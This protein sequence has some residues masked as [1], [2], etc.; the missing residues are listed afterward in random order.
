MK[1]YKPCLA[2][3]VALTVTTGSTNVF[4]QSSS[5]VDVPV[6]IE[7]ENYSSMV[8]IRL[9]ETSDNGGGT[10]VGWIQDRDYTEYNISVPSSGQYRITAR[11][12]SN[13]DG[14]NIDFRV[15]GETL[16]S[17]EV[18]HTGGWNDFRNEETTLDLREG[19][20][21]LQLLYTSSRDGHLLNVNSFSIASVD[22]SS[23]NPVPPP[24]APP[25]G[26][27]VTAATGTDTLQ[28]AIDEVNSEGGGTVLL[29]SG[30]YNLTQEIRP[31][32][33]VHILG[34]GSS[35]L[36]RWHNSVAD[37]INVPVFNITYGSG[38]DMGFENFKI[39]CRVDI[40][41]RDDRNRT[42]TRGI[43]LTGGGSQF[44]PGSAAFRNIT[45]KDLEIIN[46]G[47]E[48]IQIKGAHNVE[49]TDLKLRDNGWGT[50]DLWHNFYLK[51]VSK[52][53][54]RQTGSDTG[55]MK[56]SPSGHGMR[57]SDLDDVYLEG[58]SVFGNADHGIHMDNVSDFRA[59][60]LDL[61][62]NCQIPNGTCRESA[63]YNDCDYD[64]TS[65]KE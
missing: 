51:R 48:G 6:S 58:V 60:G 30:T 37:R 55:Y 31:R 39:D 1:N 36:V 20:Q 14:G 22:D 45:L 18:D 50:T 61:G 54:V 28:S 15:G 56:D 44:D 9:G 4:A 59:Y 12:A 63:C 2:A 57:M 62:G 13:T 26:T 42:D 11:V 10:Y 17:I 24:V 34:V 8:G 65:S 40:S 16:G 3:V 7:A 21:T 53:V 33:N 5:Y 52:V 32:N 41:D 49:A 29:Q 38:N 27:V 23:S 35:S 46:C 25:G 43:Y 19:D 64:L 47:G